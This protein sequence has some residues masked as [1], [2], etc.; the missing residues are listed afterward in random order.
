MLLGLLWFITAAPVTSLC[1]N[2]SGNSSKR[3]TKHTAYLHF[4]WGEKVWRP[5]WLKNCRDEQR[6]RPC[7]SG[8]LPVCLRPPAD[9]KSRWRSFL[10][11]IGSD[12]F[13]PLVWLI[14]STGVPLLLAATLQVSGSLLSPRL[15]FPS[16]HWVGDG[17]DRVGANFLTGGARMGS[18][19]WE[20]SEKEQIGGVCWWP[21]T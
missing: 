7:V 1:D 19:N 10:R 3:T 2:W 8:Q 13:C 17:L 14:P 12:P 21:V 6:G 16:M 15:Q 4:T 20:G 18:Y 5:R 11:S 9:Q